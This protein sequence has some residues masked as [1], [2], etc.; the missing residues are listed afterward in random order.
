VLIVRMVVSPARSRRL[1]HRDL[2]A[3]DDAVAGL[4]ER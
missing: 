3:R 4:F 2:R 1:A